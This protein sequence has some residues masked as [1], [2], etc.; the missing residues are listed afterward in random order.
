MGRQRVGDAIAVA[1]AYDWAALGD[2]VDVGGGDGSLLIALLR[3]HPTLRGTVID[4]ASAVESATRALGAAGLSDRGL[5]QTGS[6]FEPLPP[7]GSGYI[8]SRIL[9]DWDDGDVRRILE[10]CADAAGPA[11]R[12][13][14]VED[15]D[16]GPGGS[17]STEMDL[18]MLAYFLG[19]E[20]T[21]VRLVELARAA[22][23]TLGTVTPLPP[24]T[25]IE[26]L[27]ARAT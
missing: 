22:G 9:H 11:G 21:L 19:R 12:V 18:R 15:I 13:I 14:V 27:P 17:V 25:I 7:G 4:L 23:L 8:L 10:R 20:R 3:A 24:R 2:V 6:F 26:L 1:G 5:A 16:A